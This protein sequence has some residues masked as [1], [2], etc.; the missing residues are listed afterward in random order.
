MGRI[1]RL[2]VGAQATVPTPLRPELML[3]PLSIPPHCILSSNLIRF[4]GNDQE[5]REKTRAWC[6]LERGEYYVFDDFDGGHHLAHVYAARTT[7]AGWHLGG[8]ELGHQAVGNI[9][10]CDCRAGLEHITG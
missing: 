3:W 6:A 2:E 4:R 8:S 7:G 10:G 1:V 9:G 5:T